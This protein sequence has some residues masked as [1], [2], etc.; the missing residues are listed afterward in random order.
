MHAYPYDA[1]SSHVSESYEQAENPGRSLE[2]T[3]D[4]V[5]SPTIWRFGVAQ[6][7]S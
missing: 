4:S 6:M 5:T 3:V 7:M 1:P 2:D